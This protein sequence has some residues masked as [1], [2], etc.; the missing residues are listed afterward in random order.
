MSKLLQALRLGAQPSYEG[1]NRSKKCLI[2]IGTG[3][4]SFSLSN[5]LNDTGLY[6]VIAFIDEEPW[7]HRT[8]MNGVSVYYPCELVSLAEKKL[9]SAVIAFQGEGW[10]MDS[11][12]LLA[13]RK[14]EIE[15]VLVPNLLYLGD[16]ADPTSYKLN[17]IL[18]A[19]RGIE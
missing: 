12:T 6:Q 17:F 15:F 8:E 18:N 11:D 1:Q 19:L 5:C 13:L 2:M 4:S 14:R 3:Y 10:T 9:V 7:N 16:I